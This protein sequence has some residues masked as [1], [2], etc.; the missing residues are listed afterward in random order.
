MG[1]GLGDGELLALAEQDGEPLSA[2][3]REKPELLHG[4]A[5][6]VLLQKRFGIHNRDILEA[7]ALHTS[8]EP[9][10]GELARALYIVDKI[11]FTREGVN[12][13][14]REQLARVLDGRG[15]FDALF[16]AILEDNVRYLRSKAMEVSE[17]TLRVLEHLKQGV[18]GAEKH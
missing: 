13:S 6:A 18:S 1:K 4:R 2:L 8:G 10:M 5:A 14:L 9:G 15:D 11:E 7:V 17:K 3:E 16:R 12:N